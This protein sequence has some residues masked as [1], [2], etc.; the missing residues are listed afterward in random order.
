MR[1]HAIAA[2]PRRCDTV[3]WRHNTLR[4]AKAETLGL[5]RVLLIR[6]QQVPSDAAVWLLLR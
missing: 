2:E 3:G 4:E 1:R 5:L 6:H